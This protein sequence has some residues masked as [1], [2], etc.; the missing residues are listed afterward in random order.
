MNQKEINRLQQQN[1]AAHVPLIDIGPYLDGSDKEGVAK[2]VFDA[3]RDTG[4]FLIKNHGV[5]Q[6]LIDEI[7]KR[8]HEFF[9]LP[10]EAKLKVKGSHNRGYF[11]YGEE[12]LTTLYPALNAGVDTKLGDFKEGF[13]VGREKTAD[14]P[15][16][17]HSFT[18]KQFNKWPEELGEAWKESVMR[19]FSTLNELG[20]QMMR[21]FAIAL[22]LMETKIG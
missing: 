14:D 7:F 16:M 21:I 20:V 11:T 22:G 12:N 5:P 13:D 18:S 17:Q 2:K 6:S 1:D 4:F 9:E 10:E 15:D 8:A 19:Y 3:C